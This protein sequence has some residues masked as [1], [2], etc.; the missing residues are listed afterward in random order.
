MSGETTAVRRPRGLCS[1]EA[2]MSVAHRA[3]GG[4][5]V[6]GHSYQVLAWFDAWQDMDPL[7]AQLRAVVAQLDHKTLP[8]AMTWAEDVA[9]WIGSQLT[10]C[11]VVEVNRPMEGRFCSVTL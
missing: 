10:N 6:H 11:R 8:D 9:V 7:E 4:G 5:E 3:K 2:K 1:V